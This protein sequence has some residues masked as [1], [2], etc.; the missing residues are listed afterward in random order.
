M[1]SIKTPTYDEKYN[2]AGPFTKFPGEGLPD[3]KR[4]ITTHDENGEGVFLPSDNGD[5]HAMMGNGRGVQSVIYTTKEAQIELNDEAD[6]KFAKE[7][8]S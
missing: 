4:Y 6:I 7:P 5:H 2:E 1:A 3:I 8:V